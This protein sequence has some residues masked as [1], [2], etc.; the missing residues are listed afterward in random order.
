[1]FVFCLLICSNPDW[2]DLVLSSLPQPGRRTHVPLSSVSAASPSE[3][4]E[5]G[6]G[7]RPGE[8][9]RACPQSVG[10]RESQTLSPC[11]IKFPQE[12]EPKRKQSQPRGASLCTSAPKVIPGSAGKWIKLI[13]HLTQV[14][15]CPQVWNVFG[16]GAPANVSVFR[17]HECGGRT[18][19]QVWEW[20]SVDMAGATVVVRQCGGCGSKCVLALQACEWIDSCGNWRCDRH[21]H[22]AWL[23]QGRRGGAL[24]R[25]VLGFPAVAPSSSFFPNCS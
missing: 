22:E 7:G 11:F 12:G 3:G 6:V 4:G 19:W 8:Q 5:P 20:R 21:A 23:L 14:L 17:P 24:L 15:S 18:A 1:M 25:T 16:L 9:V 10:R 13:F 2:G